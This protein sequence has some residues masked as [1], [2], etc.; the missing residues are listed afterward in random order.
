MLKYFIF[1]ISVLFC[2]TSF[3]SSIS[4]ILDSGTKF[5]S[6]NS[7]EILN[8]MEFGF[9]GLAGFNES[10]FFRDYNTNS[11]MVGL[12]FDVKLKHKISNTRFTPFVHY[13]FYAFGPTDKTE[14]NSSFFGYFDSY[15]GRVDIYL[16]TAF[17]INS[18]INSRIYFGSKIDLINDFSFSPRIGYENKTISTSIFT[19]QNAHYILHSSGENVDSAF[20]TAGGDEALSMSHL[21]IKFDTLLIGT[22]VDKKINDSFAVYAGADYAYAK[23]RNRNTNHIK[24][25]SGTNI[26]SGIIYQTSKNFALELS[27]NYEFRKIQFDESVISSI[28]NKLFDLHLFYFKAGF[29]FGGKLI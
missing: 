22:R 1:F 27:A 19:D 16:K 4:G 5:I 17:S 20:A 28:E 25:A 13:S 11:P 21:N 26:E 8:H 15:K 23:D 29:R 2:K 14:T 3:A 12:G 18:I 9:H 10:N 24:G 6:N 7:E